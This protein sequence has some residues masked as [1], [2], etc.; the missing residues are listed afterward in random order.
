MDISFKCPTCDQ[1]LEVDATG[2]GS[3]IECPSCSAVITVPTP[4][5]APAVAA[6]VNS[7]PPEPPKEEKHYNVP[8][9]EHAPES[10]L[11]QKPT[12]RPLDVVA[13]EA[14]RTLRIRTFKRSECIEVGHDRFDEKVSAF[15]EK[16]GQTHIVSILPVNY[17]YEELATRKI[18]V[19]YGVMVVYKG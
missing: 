11:I 13:K 14:D 17:S 18:L 1:E 6:V 15:L 7:A 9:H 12:T 10:T 8:V 2:A 4:R 16:V 5:T 19:D 3:S